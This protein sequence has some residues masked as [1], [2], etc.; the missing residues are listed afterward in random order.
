M[1]ILAFGTSTSSTSI[2]HKL[3]L[4][5]ASL[6][7]GAQVDELK[8]RDFEMPLYCPDREAEI[9]KP[10]QAL[11]FIERM[12]KADL[13]VFSLAEHNGNYT[14]AFKNL[15]DWISRGQKAFQNKPILLL[16][17]SPGPRG[18][19]TIL[20][21]AKARIPFD[22]GDIK[23]SFSLPSFSQ[24]FDVENNTITNPELKQQLI[25]IVNSISI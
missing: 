11:A 2:N 23:G 15:Y 25:D 12:S 7:D 8:L 5:A 1:K 17:T 20:D 16:A 13:L 18:G 24:N 6:F 3:A 14:A 21:I 10:A 22:G 4:Y 19:Q 9:G